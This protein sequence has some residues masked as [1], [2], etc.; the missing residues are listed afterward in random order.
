MRE[1][2]LDTLPHLI[3]YVHF[4]LTKRI[5]TKHCVWGLPSILAHTIENRV[6][7][8]DPALSVSQ[9]KRD[10]WAE[11]RRFHLRAS[12]TR[13][14][15]GAGGGVEKFQ[16]NIVLGTAPFKFAAPLQRTV[17]SV[18]KSAGCSW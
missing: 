11:T 14:R 15:G 2:Y 9:Q 1:T 17:T 5:R 18:V 10:G 4:T 13:R 12:G 8:I 6:R 3:S 7:A 16:I